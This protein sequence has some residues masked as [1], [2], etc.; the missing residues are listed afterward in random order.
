MRHNGD[1]TTTTTTKNSTQ[2]KRE[3]AARRNAVC[4]DAPERRLDVERV[5]RRRHVLDARLLAVAKAVAVQVVDVRH[6]DRVLK[7]ALCLL[8]VCLFLRFFKGIVVF[9]VFV[10]WGEA[11]ILESSS[12]STHTQAPDARAHKT[13]HTQS[14]LENNN[15]QLTQW[16]HSNSISP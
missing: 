2:K 15:C 8:F 7:H 3:D 14:Q 1:T 5:A 13:Q 16:P 11:S 12:S 9:V 6:V 4:R 10:F